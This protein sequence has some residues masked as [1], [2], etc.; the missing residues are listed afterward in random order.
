MA[1][2]KCPECGKEMSDKAE[3]CPNCG[4]PN[5]NFDPDIPR[6][7]ELFTPCTK[8]P[9]RKAK[10]TCSVCGKHMCT[11]CAVDSITM[12]DGTVYCP[13]CYLEAVKKEK[14]QL[15][16]SQIFSY[17]GLAWFS[18]FLIVAIGASIYSVT[19]SAPFGMVLLTFWFYMAF[20]SLLPLFGKMFMNT[21]GTT[22]GALEL[23]KNFWTTVF[24]LLIYAF[25]AGPIAAVIAAVNRIKN[26]K[27]CKEGL[28]NDDA[29]IEKYEKIVAERAAA[30]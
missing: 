26:L 18:F 29:A 9:D 15:K 10:L 17:I 19:Q 16:R 14:K 6:A 24:I 27:A 30:A 4:A 7:G 20:A 25:I 28:K 5:P 3:K 21:A 23:H 8:H 2:M 12:N 11:V 1:I 22:L 13:E